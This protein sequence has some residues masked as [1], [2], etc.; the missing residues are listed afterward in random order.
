MLSRNCVAETDRPSR[1]PRPPSAVRRCAPIQRPHRSEI[2]RAV[3][4]STA[5]AEKPGFKK[6]C[7]CSQSR[8]APHEKRRMGVRAP[9]VNLSKKP[10]LPAK[11]ISASACSDRP[12][13]ARVTKA[14]MFCVSVPLTFQSLVKRR[15]AV[16]AFYKQLLRPHSF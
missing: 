6:H 15:V 1:N 13:R 4:E 7:A 3:V 11:A 10:A 2:S 14:E 8:A 12:R 16:G 9:P 5:T